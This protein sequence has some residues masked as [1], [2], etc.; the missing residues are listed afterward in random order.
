MLLVLKKTLNLVA[1]AVENVKDNVLRG[2]SHLGIIDD[3]PKNL[4]NLEDVLEDKRKGL[5]TDKDSVVVAARIGD[6]LSDPTYNRTE[7]ISYGNCER[8]LKQLKGFSYKA[9]GILFAFVRPDYSVVVTQGNHRTT[10]LW[11]VT[12]D[13]NVRIPVNL[14]FHPEDISVERMIEIESE[15]HNADCAFRSN[16]DNDSKFKSAFFSKQSWALLIFQ[17]LTPF[18]I[19]IAGTLQNARFRCHSY[20]YI[21]KARKEA[22]DEN[23]KTVLNVFTGLYKDVENPNVEILGN[24]V[25]AG[26]V[27]LN[28]FGKHVAEVNAKNNDVDS[29]AGM[30]E[31]YFRDMEIQLKKAR[32]AGYPIAIKQNITQSDICKGS[33]VYKG[34]ELYVCRF[35][36]L[37]NDYVETQGWDISDRNSTAVPIISGREF[38][39]FT[40]KL[41]PFFRQTLAEVAKAP[42]VHNK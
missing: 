27:F 23:V 10:M 30:I 35:I 26:A 7:D 37:Y 28:V 3:I 11:M 36:S 13:P 6:L 1:L 38:A 4:Q 25:R 19:G 16:Q 15:N 17:F 32:D 39:N 14:N 20:N 18:W 9:S 31:Y 5:Y 41:D 40:S 21:S 42:V 34:I 33:K 29:F 2:L 12:E 22:G 8:D 24:F